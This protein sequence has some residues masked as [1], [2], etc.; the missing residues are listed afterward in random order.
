MLQ[1]N[2]VLHVFLFFIEAAVNKYNIFV[3][4]TGK[5]SVHFKSKLQ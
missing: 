5:T 4:K 2:F 3:L 1:P